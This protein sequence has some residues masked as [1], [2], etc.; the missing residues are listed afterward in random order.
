MGHGGEGGC[1]SRSTDNGATW[2]TPVQNGFYYYGIAVSGTTWVMVGTSGY[3]SRKQHNCYADTFAWN[4][5]SGDF[6][7]DISMYPIR[8]ITIGTDIVIRF[9]A[10]TGHIV[11]DTWSFTQEA[12]YGLKIADKDGNVYAKAGNG[13]FTVTSLTINGD[14]IS[15]FLVD[16]YYNSSSYYWYRLYSDG[17]FE[18]G[19]KMSVTSDGQAFTLSPLTAAGKKF[20][21]TNWYSIACGT[22]RLDIR[23]SIQ[24]RRLV[25]VAYTGDDDTFNS[26]SVDNCLF[27][28]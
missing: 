27:E 16:E 3:W 1:W 20:T 19:M 9:P 11:G 13:V 28:L 7:D 23:Q 12:I 24:R 10:Y 15:R 4:K 2:S 25:F 26:A 17:W 14:A 8:N 22:Q 21:D 18:C 5:D 6:S